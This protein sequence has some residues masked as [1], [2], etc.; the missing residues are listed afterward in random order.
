MY[1]MIVDDYVLMMIEWL[2]AR[3]VEE[4]LYRR[5]LIIYDVS[6]AP[7]PSM[8]IIALEN[9]MSFSKMAVSRTIVWVK[10]TQPPYQLERAEDIAFKWMS[11]IAGL[12]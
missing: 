8:D 3:H 1:D 6:N 10:V 7:D 11:L 9:R 2:H 5:D 4:I 12:S